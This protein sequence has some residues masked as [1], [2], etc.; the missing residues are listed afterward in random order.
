ME[1]AAGFSPARETTLAAYGPSL[2]AHISDSTDDGKSTTT[3]SG[4]PGQEGR[5]VDYEAG[6]VERFK[7]MPGRISRSPPRCG[8]RSSSSGRKTARSG[9][10][11][12]STTPTASIP[13]RR[14]RRTATAGPG[15]GGCVDTRPSLYEDEDRPLPRRGR[16]PAWHKRAADTGREVKPDVLIQDTHPQPDARG[17]GAPL[18]GPEHPIRSRQGGLPPGPTSCD[19]P[20]HR[21]HLGEAMAAADKRLGGPFL[22]HGVIRCANRSPQQPLRARWLNSPS[23]RPLR[24]GHRLARL[25][26]TEDGPRLRE[27]GR[28][29]NWTR[30]GPSTKARDEVAAIAA[31]VDDN[32]TRPLSGRQGRSLPPR[33]ACRPLR[34]HRREATPATSGGRRSTA[35]R[36]SLPAPCRPATSRPSTPGLPRGCGHPS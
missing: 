1:G 9:S 19:V 13:A 27:S 2:H 4:S 24:T 35:T 7:G 5:T 11:C 8:P 34:R 17:A 6:L 21:R 14:G 28:A 30:S 20:G 23:T 31:L 16:Q 18:R 36:P 3:R 22:D 12:S 25:S 10:G 32:G 29:G 33:P 15:R 26:S